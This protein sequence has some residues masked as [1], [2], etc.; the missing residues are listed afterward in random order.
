ML[1]RLWFQLRWYLE[2]MFQQ[3]LAHD[4]L[5]RAA[6]MMAD[7]NIGCLPVIEDTPGHLVGMLT[8]TDVLLHVANGQVPSI[9]PSGQM[10]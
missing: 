2:Q 3:F 5:A 4:C 8:I 9:E 10:G 1:Q 6:G 7:N